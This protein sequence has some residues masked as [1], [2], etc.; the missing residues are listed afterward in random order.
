[1]TRPV[2]LESR[3]RLLERVSAYI[4][5]HGLHDLSLRP[6]AEAVNSSPR[7]LL[8]HFGSKEELVATVLRASRDRQF[9]LF[10]SMRTSPLLTPRAVCGAAWATISDPK[11]MPYVH[12]LFEAYSIALRDPQRFPGFL[13]SFVEDWLEFLANPAWSNGVSREQ[14]RAYATVILAGFRGFMLDLAATGDL[15]RVNAA[16]EIWSD[17]IDAE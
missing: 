14:M 2:D 12:L 16:F 4:V 5:K 9:R 15:K 11:F 17:L 7:M 6:M 1:M 8:Y 10:E 3:A 13:D